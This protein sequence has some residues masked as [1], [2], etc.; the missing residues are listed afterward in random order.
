MK[1]FVFEENQ[2]D[3]AMRY[4]AEVDGL[5]GSP[6][7]G[8]AETKEKAVAVLLYNLMVM[9]HRTDWIQFCR[10]KL[11]MSQFEFEDRCKSISRSSA[12]SK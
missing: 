7:V 1:I 9:S 10:S 3:P 4:C 6:P 12:P 5:P 11:D 2:S 8:R